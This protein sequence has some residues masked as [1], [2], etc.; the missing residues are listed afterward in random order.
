MGNVSSSESGS[1]QR[2][3]ASSARQF[4]KTPSN[5]DLEME[6]VSPGEVVVESEERALEQKMP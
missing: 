1:N 2:S 5:G 6:D 4:L 3:L